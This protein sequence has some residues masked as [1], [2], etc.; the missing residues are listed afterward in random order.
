MIF[1]K[2]NFCLLIGI[3]AV[4]FCGICQA[5]YTY[6]N[7]SDESRNRTKSLFEL[8]NFIAENFIFT[9]IGVSMFTFPRHL[10][11]FWFIIMAFIAI[12]AGRA[13][14]VYPLTFILNLGR[15]N[16]IPMN[17]QHVLFFSGLRGLYLIFFK[18]FQYL[19]LLFNSNNF[20]N[21]ILTVSHFKLRK[22]H[23]KFNE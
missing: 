10:W 20:F 3:V 15:N 18:L 16:K 2:K 13:L 23:S 4:L 21:F 6:N 19:N 9:Y 14:N 1:Y 12:A 22:I 7:L 8:C 11:S 5:H 17:F